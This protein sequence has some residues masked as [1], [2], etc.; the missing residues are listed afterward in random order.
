MIASINA[1]REKHNNAL[2]TAIEALDELHTMVEIPPAK[3][4]EERYLT[5]I[6]IVD[7]AVDAEINRLAEDEKGLW[8][9]R[10]NDKST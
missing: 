10:D 5:A 7:A 9:Y 4:M 1:I 3:H 8:S 2:Y 6:E